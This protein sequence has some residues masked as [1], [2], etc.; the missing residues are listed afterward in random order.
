MNAITTRIL[1]KINPIRLVDFCGGC[2]VDVWWVLAVGCGKGLAL[3]SGYNPPHLVWPNCGWLW[4]HNLTTKPATFLVGLWCKCGG[5]YHNVPRV[6]PHPRHT[7]A[8]HRPHS[9]VEVWRGRINRVDE[10]QMAELLAQCCDQRFSDLLRAAGAI[11]IA[12][13]GSK[14][15][16]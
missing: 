11:S 16:V 3:H 9:V 4:H 5:G 6:G 7:S 8:T 2:V 12:V 1:N 15:E 13:A 10:D 14:E